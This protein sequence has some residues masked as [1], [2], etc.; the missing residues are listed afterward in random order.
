MS[1][2]WAGERGE[3][4][5]K[6]E[7]IRLIGGKVSSFCWFRSYLAKANGLTRKKAYL[8]SI[9]PVPPS[10]GDKGKDKSQKRER[11]R[12]WRQSINSVIR[13]GR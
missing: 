9:C 4:D 11:V 12:R 13:A 2:D 7:Q 10:F 6:T 1:G 3:E 8:F 5:I